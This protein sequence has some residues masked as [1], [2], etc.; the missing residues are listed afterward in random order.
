VALVVPVPAVSTSVPL[1]E[2]VKAIERRDLN[3]AYTSPKRRDSDYVMDLNV[4]DGTKRYR[5]AGRT[6]IL[7]RAQVV[8]TV[9]RKVPSVEKHP[10]SDAM[11][12]LAK[13]DLDATTPL[14]EGSHVYGTEPAGGALVDLRQPV[15]VYA[16]IEIPRVTG[17]TLDVARGKLADV[18]LNVDAGPPREIETSNPSLIGAVYVEDLPTAQAPRAGEI[19]RKRSIRGVRLSLIRYVEPTVVVPNV[20]ELTVPQ[21]RE[22]LA[23]RDLRTNVL[24]IQIRITS[25][26]GLDGVQT[27]HAQDPTAGTR[28][29]KQT[30]V[31]VRVT[32]WKYD[33]E[34]TKPLVSYG[35]FPGS[36]YDD[37][38]R[39][40]DNAIWMVTLAPDR[41]IATVRVLHS[42][43]RGGVYALRLVNDDFQF[44]GKRCFTYA[45]VDESAP[46]LQLRMP[47][48]GNG[49]GQLNED[50]VWLYTKPGGLRFQTKPPAF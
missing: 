11:G 31:N 17:D 24:T 21:A 15:K 14:G 47:I 39:R 19:V 27:V 36:A 10:W 28:V 2:A 46:F 49:F 6:Y 3:V 29:K 34:P 1:A 18:D 42:G 37:A 22:R 45:F 7:P 48:D 8:L 30:T 50:G 12:S 32:Q 9:G 20:I 16:G 35:I 41:K 40:L 5:A 38:I 23:D 25:D 13:V 4:A 26:Q 33:V 43:P 44:L